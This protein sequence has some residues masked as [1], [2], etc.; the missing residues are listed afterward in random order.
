MLLYI[1]PAVAW[2]VCALW[3]KAMPAGWVKC[4]VCCVS[5]WTVPPALC[6]TCQHCV[7]CVLR[8]VQ[9]RGKD[10]FRSKGT[11]CIHG[12]KRMFNFQG[13]HE[14]FQFAASKLLTEADADNPHSEIVFIGRDLDKDAIKQVCSAPQHLSDVFF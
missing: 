2:R 10:I 11:L 7:T 13:V 6:R 1:L 3:C 12:Q 9:E 4:D 8:S 14:T 5:V